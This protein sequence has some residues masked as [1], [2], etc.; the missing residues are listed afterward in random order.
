MDMRSFL[1]IFGTPLL[2]TALDFGWRGSLA[3][4]DPDPK[5]LRPGEA[6]EVL[7]GA[8]IP[9][10]ADAVV[11]VEFTR[12]E[13]DQVVC[14]RDAPPGCNLLVRGS[15][16]SA[17]GTIVQAG[18]VLTPA[19]TGLLAAGGL[20]R[21]SVY[22]IPRVAVVATGDEVVAPGHPLRPGQLYASNLVTLHSWLRHF[23]M[24]ARNGGCGRRSR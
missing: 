10:G 12:R 5:T 16:V 18:Q 9:S 17:G 24:R 19:L 1:R 6:I 23:G 8:I 13:S 11:S 3:A 4:G 14:Y 7:T 15:D 22:P 20:D 2:K 21:V